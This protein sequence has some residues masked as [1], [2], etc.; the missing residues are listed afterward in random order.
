[1]IPQIVI[2]TKHPERVVINIIIVIIGLLGRV[3]AKRDTTATIAVGVK[4]MRRKTR[5]DAAQA[6]IDIVIKI[7]SVVRGMNAA[8]GIEGVTDTTA[9]AIH[10]LLNHLLQVVVADLHHLLLKDIGREIPE[11]EII[12]ATT[13]EEVQQLILTCTHTSKKGRWKAWLE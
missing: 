8:V 5:A 10:P 9:V 7:V 6:V 3:L 1:M 2:T 12:A 13:K 4:D 11:E